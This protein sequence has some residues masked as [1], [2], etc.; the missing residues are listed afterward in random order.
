ISIT[1]FL[2]PLNT[3]IFPNNPIGYIGLFIFALAYINGCNLIDGLD[4]IFV[5]IG[6]ATSLA[7]LAI[8]YH[9]QS[10][11]SMMFSTLIIASLVSF[12][13]YNKEP[14][15]IYA[16]EIGGSLLGMLLFIQANFLIEKFNSINHQDNLPTKL[17]A[18]ILIVSI[19]PL[20]ELGITFTRRIIFKKSPFRGDQLHLHHIIKAK[21]NLKASQIAN[22]LT[23]I[24]LSTEL[25]SYIV[26]TIA[27]QSIALYSSVATISTTYSI[28]CFKYWKKSNS[29]THLNDIFMNLNEKPIYIVDGKDIDSLYLKQQVASIK[30]KTNIAA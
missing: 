22:L 17:I 19:Y 13:Y 14:A 5:K 7:F 30:A 20:A 24:Y 21:Y 9:Y 12:Y 16:G 18:T 25:I 11:P 10:L 6:S 23:I 1:L 27:T 3:I 15:K 29:K 4:T 8:S 2:V 26:S 28:I